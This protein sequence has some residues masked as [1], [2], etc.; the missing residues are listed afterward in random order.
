MAT[1]AADGEGV[2]RA[3]CRHGLDACLFVRAQD[4]AVRSEELHVAG[5]AAVRRSA[6][7]ELSVPR[8]MPGVVPDAGRWRPARSAAELVARA[9]AAAR[10]EAREHLRSCAQ[11][12]V[13]LTAQLAA[14]DEIGQHGSEQ[15]DDRDCNPR[16]TR[17]ARAQAHGAGSR[18]E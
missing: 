13:D 6:L 7:V 4:V 3:A 1:L 11:R 17:D 16:S 14:D 12:A 8:R 15:N 18:S 10:L 9:T 5:R 2:R